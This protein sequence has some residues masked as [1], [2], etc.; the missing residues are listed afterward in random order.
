MSVTIE[1]RTSRE[2]QRASLKSPLPTRAVAK[3]G[4][5]AG[6]LWGPTVAIA[7]LILSWSVFSRI[8][9]SSLFPGPLETA[10][11]G[12]QLMRD[13]TLFR[14]MA[15]SMQR[16]VIGFSIGSVLGIIV[17]L[18]VG[19][20]RTARQLLHGPIQ[21]FRFIPAIAW[22]SPVVVW[23]GIGETAK[24]VLIIYTTIFIVAL[25]TIS[26][27]A[28]IGQN[29]IRA[30]QCLGAS[31]QFLFLNV[32][33]PA[34]VGHILVGMRIAMGNSFMTIVAA[35]MIAADSGLGFLIFSS[36]TFLAIDVI[37]VAIVVLGVLGLLSDLLLASAIKRF[38]SRFF[39][40][41]I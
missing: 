39:A 4:R 28:S 40:E 6:R 18:A 16:I 9:D 30:A 8:I 3:A 23:L 7:V 1:D 14:D 25:N 22:I 10:E 37:F 33:V 35:E 2:P 32:V 24:I 17:G 41:G 19:W 29:K 20:F 38:G 13:G 11:T 12:Y 34:T 26:G 36:R 31:P 21:Y 5:L 27:C 15:I